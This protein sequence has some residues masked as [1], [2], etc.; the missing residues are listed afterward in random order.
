VSDHRVRVLLYSPA[1]LNVIDGSSIWVESVAAT[2]HEHPLI[3]VTIPLKTAERRA[4][5]TDSLRAMDRVTLVPPR[6]TA[7]KGAAARQPAMSTEE[8]LDL[9]ESLHAARPFDAVLLRSFALTR[10]AAERVSLRD[11]L[12]SCY[13]LEPER[14]IGS[15]EH[16]AE[17]EAICRGSRYVVAQ[18]EEMRSVLETSVPAARGR[19]ILLPPAIP[20]EAP[21]RP[22]PDRPVERLIYTGKFHPFYPV[23]QLIDAFNELR[24]ERPAL[25]FHIA[26]DKI[27][28]PAS[29]PG[30]APGLERALMET[31]G[32]VWHGGLPRSRVEALLGQGG[33]ALSVWDK[34]HGPWM[35]DLVVSTKLLDYCSVGL[36][37][38][39]SRTAAQ[40][41]MLGAD[42]PLFVSAVDETLPLVRELFRDPELYAAAAERTRAASR[43]FTYPE[44]SARLAPF[45]SGGGPLVARERLPAAPFTVGVLGGAAGLAARVIELLREH[46]ERY[47][48]STW[49]PHDDLAGWLTGVGV[50][51]TDSTPAGDDRLARAEASGA[52]VVRAT[53]AEE[54]AALVLAGSPLSA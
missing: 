34:A 41:R 5:I 48:L 32:V 28:R 54:A 20:A 44:V 1:D 7:R 40:E 16:R 31:D 13:I 36:P 22:E 38:V 2:L 6:K 25:E 4:V 42:Y 12:W 9:I 29:D 47:A 26:G 15:D 14:D 24:R 10:A 18:S 43:P 49:A 3:E 17:L 39:L 8:A 46:D 30:F 23:T 50:V 45:L 33:V 51:L 11:R 35:N 37:V 21:V 19:T 27:Y 52:R 53:S